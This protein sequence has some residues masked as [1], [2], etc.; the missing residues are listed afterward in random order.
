MKANRGARAA[1]S[2]G[3]SQTAWFRIPALLFLR[4]MNVGE[5]LGYFLCEMGTVVSALGI[6]RHL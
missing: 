2:M 4:C 3:V 5:S 1:K 6:V